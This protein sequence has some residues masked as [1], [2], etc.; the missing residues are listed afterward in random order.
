LE[1]A[2][3]AAAPTNP[4]DNAQK[5]ANDLRVLTELARFK[6]GIAT[7]AELIK[8][9]ELEETKFHRCRKRL[10]RASMIESAPKGR[11]G[12]ALTLA[13]QAAVSAAA[14]ANSLQAA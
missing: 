1:P 10:I 14:T 5:D 2:R 6:N 3:G 4:T 12:H 7:T 11:K 8:A 9:T 13:G